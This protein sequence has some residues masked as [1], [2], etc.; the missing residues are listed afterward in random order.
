MLAERK[1]TMGALLKRR[2]YSYKPL[3]TAV[4]AVAA[5]LPTGAGLPHAEAAF[6]GRNGF[7]AIPV[8]Q[9]PLPPIVTVE[10]SFDHDLFTFGPGGGVPRQI[11]SG[12]WA[13]LNPA[14]SPDGSQI[15]FQRNEPPVPG[16]WEIYVV[17]SDGTGLRN[18]TNTPGS[19]EQHPAWSPD[20]KRIVFS[21]LDPTPSPEQDLYD[22][23]ILDIASGDVV[24]LTSGPRSEIDA[25]WSPDGHS[26]AFVDTSQGSPSALTVIRPDGS[27][28][29]MV[30]DTQ[31]GRH[32]SWS[33][34]GSKILFG[35]LTQAWVVNEDGSGLQSLTP[36]GD[37]TIA[38]PG[39]SPDGSWIT[40]VSNRD[41]AWMLYKMRLDGS[42]VRR[43]IDID[44]SCP[45]GHPDWG[46]RP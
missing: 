5:W 28:R 44:L 9:A 12:T 16:M 11:T 40:F 32:P 35:S 39:W 18:L 34:D 20:G 19:S 24:Q 33:P 36:E 1:A 46:P 6:P 41:G 31:E 15:V 29:R 37:P 26:I 25:E 38:H 45:C 42:N 17:N 14:W 7:V 22:L 4:L 8:L 21:R 2:R 30:Q 13:D 27:G 23:H 43:L 3:L 10:E